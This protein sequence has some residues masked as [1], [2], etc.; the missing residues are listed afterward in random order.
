MGT[1]TTDREV[2]KAE[3]AGSVVARPKV[4]KA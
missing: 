4:W 2:I 3:R 1:S